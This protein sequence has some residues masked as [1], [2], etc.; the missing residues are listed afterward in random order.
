MWAQTELLVIRGSAIKRQR[1]PSPN[2]EEGQRGRHISFGQ[3]V[4]RFKTDM[5][6]VKRPTTDEI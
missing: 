2:E 3:S 4:L 5:E 1:E 6:V